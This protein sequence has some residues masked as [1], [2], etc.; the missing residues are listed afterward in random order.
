[1][2]PFNKRLRN[3]YVASTFVLFLSSDIISVAISDY[4]ISLT[5]RTQRTLFANMED[6]RIGY[7]KN[8]GGSNGTRAS[9]RASKHLFRQKLTSGSG[10]KPQLEHERASRWA[11]AGE[12]CNISH[13]KSAPFYATLSANSRSLRFSPTATTG[14]KRR[15]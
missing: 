9:R 8:K 15:S 12:T 1:M 14:Q 5:A 4:N 11:S 3:R 13:Q 6:K 2:S 10:L 7:K